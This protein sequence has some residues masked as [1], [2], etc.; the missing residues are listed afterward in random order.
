MIKM[1]QQLAV[2]EATLQEQVQQEQVA[3]QRQAAQQQTAAESAA[4]QQRQQP[5]NA[6]QASQAAD[7]AVSILLSPAAALFKLVRQWAQHKAGRGLQDSPHSS[8]WAAFDVLFAEAKNQLEGKWDMVGAL[9][10]VVSLALMSHA[11]HS[12]QAYL[13]L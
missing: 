9:S 8:L 1:A 6:L 2:A 10:A 3:Q 5:A 13:L 4:P 12:L 7:A 11:V